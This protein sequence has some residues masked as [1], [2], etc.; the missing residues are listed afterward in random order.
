MVGNIESQ[1]SILTRDKRIPID[2][3]DWQLTRYNHARQC[4][5][6]ALNS[7]KQGFKQNSKK[8][9]NFDAL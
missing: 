1:S 9:M 8:A 3:N 5:E 6:Q 4:L 7:E 2:I